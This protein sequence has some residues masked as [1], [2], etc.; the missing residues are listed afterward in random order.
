MTT[1][2]NDYMMF[3]RSVT[4]KSYIISA[5]L[6]LAFSLFVNIAAH[7]SIK[8]INMIESLKSVE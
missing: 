1:V 3:G 7:F 8:K 6:T 2:E 4:P 5:L